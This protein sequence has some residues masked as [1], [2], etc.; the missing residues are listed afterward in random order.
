MKKMSKGWISVPFDCEG[1][2]FY[3]ILLKKEKKMTVSYN[4]EKK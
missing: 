3:F 1:K 2:H 4:E